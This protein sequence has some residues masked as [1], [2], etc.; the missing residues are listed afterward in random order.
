MISMQS[1]CCDKEVYL[2]K[3]NAIL[4]KNL[5]LLLIS[6]VGYFYRKHINDCGLE[7]TRLVL[8]KRM[9]IVHVGNNVHV[10]KTID[11][12]IERE[13]YYIR[14]SDLFTNVKVKLLNTY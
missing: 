14:F 1:T 8:C 12:Y 4:E 3:S 10:P 9:I 7:R 2:R 6:D 13:L 5:L 11:F